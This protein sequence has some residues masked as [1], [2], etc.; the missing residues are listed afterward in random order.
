[1]DDKT[2]FYNSKLGILSIGYDDSSIISI[3]INPTG[4]PAIN[5]EPGKISD[6]AFKQISEYLE[7][8]R[9]EFT[10]PFALEGTDFQIDVWNILLN[11]PY[12]ETTSFYS[13]ACKVGNSKYA[14]AV[15]NAIHANKLLLVVPCHRVIGKTAISPVMLPAVK[16]KNYCWIWNFATRE[17]KLVPNQVFPALMY[18]A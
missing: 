4:S 8:R 5:N 3:R 15:G 18:N 1:M 7:G 11:I 13:I 6:F 2:A 9:R 14:R 16:S 12:G 10:F 17:R